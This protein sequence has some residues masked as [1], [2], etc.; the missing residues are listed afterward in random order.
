MNDYLAIEDLKPFYLYKI[1][2]RNA[3]LG[4]WRPEQKGFTIRREKF[5]DYFIFTEYHWDT[6]APF[7]TV[8]PIEE[9]EPTDFTEEDFKCITKTGK[10]GKYIIEAGYNKFMDYMIKKM[11]EYNDRNEN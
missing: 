5:G 9:L 1:R 6:G 4:I 8:R 2:A 10:Y 11:E 7:G 3:N